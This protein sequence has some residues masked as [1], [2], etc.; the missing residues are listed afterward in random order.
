MVKCPFYG[1]FGLMA[2]G[3]IAKAAFNDFRLLHLLGTERILIDSP[4]ALVTRRPD[5]SLA[6]AVWNYAPPGE[7]GASKTVE[8]AFFHLAAAAAPNSSTGI[9]V[10]P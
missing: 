5:G 2:A 1:G 4:S 10:R 9:T 8:L 6:V 7:R 3:G